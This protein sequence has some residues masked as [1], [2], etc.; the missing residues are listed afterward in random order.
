MKQAI[1]NQIKA[2]HG[3]ILGA[4]AN[5]DG[6]AVGALIG[7]ATLCGFLHIPYQILLEKIPSD[8]SELLSEVE[9]SSEPTI[10]YDT[11]ISV[12]C[13]DQGRLGIYEKAFESAVHT[14]NIDHHSTNTYFAELNEVRIVAATCE[15]VY[16]LIAFAGCPLTPHLA[17]SLY[18]G[19]LTD[20]GGFMHS[21]T[22]PATHEIVA[23]LLTCPFDFTKV[24]YE[25]MYAMSERAVRMESIAVGHMKKLDRLPCYMAH[26]TLEEMA[27]VG[28]DKEDL[29][30]IVSKIKN[31]R[32]CELAVFLYPLDDS[33]FK[34]SFRSNAPIDVAKLASYF[35]GGGHV[36]AAGATLCGSLET[37]YGQ[38][39]EAIK[40]L[41]MKG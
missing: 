24:Y 13:G 27:T 25:Q 20:T 38:I 9:V 2:S 34:A 36:R 8:F 6:D 32:G 3:I 11:F 22:T 23:Q 31:I 39:E 30:S 37:V 33:H 16:E 41:I 26:V 12:D 4:H 15:L 29:G 21:S 28:A 17:A 1:I 7:M 5:P 19:I 40:E 10:P 18:T 14:I 35:N